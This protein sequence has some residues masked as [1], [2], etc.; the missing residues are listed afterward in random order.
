MIKENRPRRSFSDILNN[1]W[2]EYD[3]WLNE[4]YTGE[5]KYEINP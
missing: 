4:G 5:F 1:V 3:K 2:Q